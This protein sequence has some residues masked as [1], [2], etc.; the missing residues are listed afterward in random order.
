M[1]TLHDLLSC[2]MPVLS[3]FVGFMCFYYPS[4]CGAHGWIFKLCASQAGI[5]PPL[6]GVC[7]YRFSDGGRMEDKVVVAIALIC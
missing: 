6:D 5:S 3:A 1:C 7:Q 4:S 2:M